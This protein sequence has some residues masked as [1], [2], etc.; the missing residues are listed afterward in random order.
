MAHCPEIITTGQS[1]GRARMLARAFGHWFDLDA[2]AAAATG[3]DLNR[4]SDTAGGLRERIVRTLA[5]RAPGGE[6][7]AALFAEALSEADPDAAALVGAAAVDGIVADGRAC[8]QLMEWEARLA[9]LATRPCG[10]PS[11][12]AAAALA[13]RRGLVALVLRGDAQAAWTIW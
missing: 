12:Q 8:A 3:L 1:Q 13:L 2:A 6:P 7:W 11:A 10:G 5:G 4:A 9:A